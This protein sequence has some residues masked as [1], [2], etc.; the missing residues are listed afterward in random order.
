MDGVG[1][2]SM[3]K[4]IYV[5]GMVTFITK[6]NKIEDWKNYCTRGMKDYCGVTPGVSISDMDKAIEIFKTMELSWICIDIANGYTSRMDFAIK[7]VREALGEAAIIVA[8]NVVT[9]QR[10]IE[11]IECGADI[12]K[13]GIGP[14]S[15]C[16][17]RIKTGVGYPQLSAVYECSIAAE[18]VGGCVMADGGCVCPGDIA[19]SFVAGADFSMIGGILAGHEESEQNIIERSY[20]TSDAEGGK[21]VIKKKKFLSFYGMSSRQAMEK[22]SGKMESY[23]ASEGRYV[24]V[25]YKG[26][27]KETLLDIFGGL[28]SSCTYIGASGV[29]EMSI[30][31]GFIRVNSQYNKWLE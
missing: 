19:K 15:V 27:V 13:V 18:S 9:P 6:F 2:F 10:T 23:K 17:T 5:S 11:L 24:E 31:G 7:Y 1:T 8:G 28:R 12:V 29:Q 20:V 25:E 14:G 3:A 22:N 26:K 30:R 21:P 16:T 4:E